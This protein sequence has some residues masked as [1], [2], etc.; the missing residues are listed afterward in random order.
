MADPDSSIPLPPVIVF[1]GYFNNLKVVE[2][3]RKRSITVYVLSN[4]WAE[5]RYS[6]Y[7]RAIH[8][9]GDARYPQEATAFLTGSASDYLKG[10]VL[11]AAGDDELEIVAKNREA[12][13]GKF[14]LDLSNPTAQLKMLDKLATYLA[15]R[16][17][18]V[19]TPR[20]WQVGSEGEIQ[21]LRDELVYP[22]IVKPKFSHVFQRKFK[23]KFIVAQD[24]DQ[25]LEGYR[26]AEGAGVETMLVEKIPG[27]DTLHS[28]Y[29]TYLD[30]EGNALF[31][32][33]KRVIR[34]Y[35]MNMGAG[36][37]HITD[38]VEGVR[39]PSLKLFRHVGLQGLAN[40]EFKYDPRDGQLKLI[41]CNARF[42][43]ANSLVA[44][45]GFDLGNFVYNRIV[46]IPQPP[47]TDFRVG[48]RLWDPLRDWRA[49]L[50][51]RK[52][53]D[54]TFSQWLA[55]I[56]HWNSLSYISW[57]DPLPSVARLWR[58]GKTILRS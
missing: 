17:A 38:R 4:R 27:P 32:F 46:G 53:G 18:G 13:A 31:D 8:L 10:C 39:E 11:L 34:R 7:A 56:M 16:E 47:L 55:S 22:L 19:T 12:L 14:R 2:S 51:L 49:F 6:R 5:A 26:V 29:Y 44:R 35:P 41:E 20:F 54:L 58:T 37:Y 42:T 1:G 15:A 23:A 3:L 40:A 36:C 30:E 21:G 48:L 52:R 24:F 28:S 45:A 25:V 57:R 9:P 50:E 43:A 33:T